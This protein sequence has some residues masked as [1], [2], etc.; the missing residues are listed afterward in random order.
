MISPEYQQEYY[1]ALL[2]KKTEYE[3]LFYVGVKTTGVFC[4]PTCPARK[5]KFEN[6]EFYATAQEALLASY[7]PCQRCRPLSHPN[8]VSDVVRI[9]VE[10]VE[11]EP[12]KRWREEDFRQLSVDE[13]TARR[14]FKKR[15][16]MTFVEY[17][18]ARRMGLALKHIRSGQTVIDTQLSTGYESSSGFRDAF[19]RIMGAAPTLL[20]ED[21]VLKASWIDTTLGPMIAVSSE[22]ALYLLEFVDRRGLEREVE[23][24]RIKT[25]SAIIP[26]MTE[27]IRL[28]EQEL[29][30]YFS[31]K[32]TTFTAP[33]QLLGSPFQQQVWDQLMKIPAGETRSYAQIASALGKPSAF[34]AVAQANGA[35]QLAIVIPCHR[36]INSNGE[37]GGYG[38][39][40]TRKTWL[41][42]HERT[43]L[44]AIQSSTFNP[45][46]HEQGEY[47][48]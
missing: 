10:A 36:V 43:P 29:N 2:E 30:T 40:L 3:G 15:F 18:R 44:Q 26:G 16:G 21:R 28:I 24:L 37:L 31:G 27:P 1:Q 48:S 7:R 34:R 41:L 39:G 35:N 9:L 14:Q 19:A 4:R 25:K 5:P 42:Q 23:R 47:N 38:G 17:A 8:H 13:S 46:I 32:S 6:C 11:K 20:T 33:L 45:L 12:E 22:E